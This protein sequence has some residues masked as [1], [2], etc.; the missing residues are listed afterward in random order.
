M[1]VDG[2]PRGGAVGGRLTGEVPLHLSRFYPLD[3]AVFETLDGD[4]G[5]AV[6]MDGQNRRNTS[7]RLMR[8]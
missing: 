4:F 8:G 5:K 3:D 2:L 7:Y 1:G 6:M